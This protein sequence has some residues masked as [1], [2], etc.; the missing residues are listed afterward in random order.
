MKKTTIPLGRSEDPK[1]EVGL[2]LEALLDTRMVIQANSGGGKSWLMRLIC[3]GVADKMP[4]VVLDWEG[5]Y[6][7]LRERADV[8]LVGADGEVPADVRGAKLL[9]RKLLELEISA[10]IDLYELEPDA[11]REYVAHFLSAV[12]DAPRRLWHPTLFFVEEAHQLCPQQ[13]SSPSR[14]AVINL[15]SL[16]GKR[17]FCGVLATQRFSK[18][19]NDAIAEG[20]NVVI[21]RTWLDAD[22]KRAGDS[23]GLV[24]QDRQVL[25][26]LDRGEFYA[27][28]PALSVN[29]VFRFHSNQVRTTHLRGSTRAAF[30]PP[31]PSEAIR[32]VLPELA[33]LAAREEEEQRTVDELRAQVEDLRR[34][35]GERPPETVRVDVPVLADGTLEHLTALRDDLRDIVD[36]LGASTGQVEEAA[37]TI[38]TQLTAVSGN[39]SGHDYTRAEPPDHFTPQFSQREMARLASLT[40]RAAGGRDEPAE[41]GAPAPGLT[42]SPQQRILDAVK[43]LEDL[44]IGQPSLVQ[45]A[46]IRGVSHTTGTFKQD[47]RELVAAGYLERAPASSVRLTPEGRSVARVEQPIKSLADLRSL[48][49]SKLPQPRAAILR[50]VA[51]LYPRPISRADLASRL[52][53]S[54]TTGTF[55]DDLR[56]LR[57]YGLVA[58]GA[59]STV[60]ATKLLFPEGLK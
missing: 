13:N 52:G 22:Q 32:D 23:L 43:Q 49:Y 34:Q 30:T 48:W 1:R 21:G 31:K 35:L 12:V 56:K 24:G 4:F 16:G 15:M 28:G 11:R 51:S 8:L 42:S 3:E 39:G 53:K 55:K 40:A 29:G 5:E 58:F 20:N 41:P 10:V 2:D 25:K 59:G 50:E 44:G 27:F 54:H 19:H 7:T 17:G 57:G 6:A 38:T 46:V 26:D 60:V 14:P 18:L 37:E 9:A 33:D 47:V 45:V 36:K